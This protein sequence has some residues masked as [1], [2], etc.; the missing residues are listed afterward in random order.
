MTPVRIALALCLLSSTGSASAQSPGFSAGKSQTGKQQSYDRQSYERQTWQTENGLPQNSVHA[1]LQGVKGYIWIGTEGGLARFDG[2]RF[3]TYS[4][5]NYPAMPSNDIR[6]LAQD[7]AGDIWAAT[8]GGAVRLHGSRI[9]SF[10]I[11]SGLPSLNVTS[12]FKNANGRITA[13]TPGSEFVWNGRKFAAIGNASTSQASPAAAPIRFFPADDPLIGAGILCQMMDRER[14]LWVGT[15]SQGLTVLRKPKF[16]VLGLRQG[17]SSDAVRCLYQTRDGAVWIGTNSGGLDRLKDGVITHFGVAEGLSSEVIIA[18]GE[19]AKGDLAVGTPDGLN[20]LCNGKVSVLTSAD[21]LADDFVRS[22]SNDGSTLYAGTRRGLT[23]MQGSSFRTY[24]TED[25]LGSNLVGAT[26]PGLNGQVWIAT[27]NGLSLLDQQKVRT[28]QVQD[29]L[30]SNIV[31]ALYRD[32]EQMLWI[33][34]QGGSLNCFRNGRFQHF[35][36]EVNLPK[37]I[38]GIAEDSGGNL[39]LSSN[40]G[41]Y[42]VERDLLLRGKGEAIAYG[43]SDGLRIN[44]SSGGGHPGLWKTQAGTLWFATPKGA[45]S[46]TPEQSKLNRLPP[47]VVIESVSID[48]RDVDGTRDLTV[49]PGHSRFAFEYAG[50]SFEAP[51]KVRYRY[52]LEGFDRQWIDAGTRR[53]AYYTNVPP[54]HYTFRVLARNNDGFWNLEGAR[55]HLR[56]QPRFYQT[57]WFLALCITAA[58]LMLYSGYRWLVRQRMRQVAGRY[59]AVLAERNRIAREIHDTLAQGFAGVSVQLELI[60]RLMGK[61]TEAAREHL[62]EARTLV[63][64]SLNEARRSIWELRSQSVAGE[65]FASRLNNL[66]HQGSK[67]GDRQIT[68]NVTGALRPLPAQL[69]NELVRIAEE[70]VRNAQRHGSAKNVDIKLDFEQKLA[71]LSVADDGAGFDLQRYEGPREGHFGLQ[72]MRER[73]ESLGGS[74]RVESRPDHGTV[75]TVEAPL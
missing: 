5:E 26:L 41:I 71:R 55:L 51:K 6:A 32:G 28:Y 58:G 50:L 53:I 66:T 39:W 16:N 12:I 36:Q 24:T 68:F 56:L 19:T 34:T 69:E 10:G 22:I 38:Y 54:G 37:I 18:L 43:T 74:F 31:T 61:S 29:G 20:I 4:N 14:N 73:A 9:E 72:G 64:E 75:I 30:T 63:K 59:D 42:R 8:A 52:R 23:A 21:G 11:E 2:Y 48:D 49:G 3:Q 27:L 17:L 25:G 13:A 47:P 1:L 40:T 67:D 60:S 62:Q 45:A 65:D 57:L 35:G 15:E 7:R 44:E 46:M 33:G 70:A